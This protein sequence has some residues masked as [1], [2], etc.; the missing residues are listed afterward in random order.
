[1]RRADCH[2]DYRRRL[3]EKT[4]ATWLRAVFVTSPFHT[5]LLSSDVLLLQRFTG[6]SYPSEDLNMA[7]TKIMI[8]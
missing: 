7:D 2:A 6:Y 1:M 4:D 8:L 3:G 5:R